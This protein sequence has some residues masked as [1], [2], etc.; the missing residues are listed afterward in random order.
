MAHPQPQQG[1][2]AVELALVLPVCVFLLALMLFVGKVLY[3]YEAAT[4]AA[5][6]GSLYLS[7]ISKLDMKNSAQIG[8]HVALAQQLIAAELNELQLTPYP[9]SVQISCGAGSCDGY[10]P[11]TTVTV[12]IH[13]QLVDNMF[14]GV[15]GWDTI[16][17]GIDVKLP[18]LGT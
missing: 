5:Y 1:I 16:S 14:S 12:S 13:L 2:A 7:S 6:A 8:N 11:P 9:P 3:C 15:T 4:K 10:L 18:Y 17:V